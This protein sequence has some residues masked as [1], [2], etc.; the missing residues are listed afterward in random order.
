MKKIL[1]VVMVGMMG[2]VALAG[3]VEVQKYSISFASAK[4]TMLT[5]E[6][7]REMDFMQKTMGMTNFEKQLERIKQM[8]IP[9]DNNW[10]KARADYIN[11]IQ[12][13]AIDKDAYDAVIGSIVKSPNEEVMAILTAEQ[14]RL[15]LKALTK[16]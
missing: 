11:I 6:T 12:E 8:E 10:F 7:K 16:R 1:V 5:S 15:I 13:A 4:A 14:N 3:P 9:M 2:G